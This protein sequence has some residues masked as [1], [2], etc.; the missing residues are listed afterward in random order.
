MKKFVYII[1]IIFLVIFLSAQELQYDVSA[2]N[3]EVPV[4]V[5]KGDRF[6]DH[7]TVDDFEVSEDGVIQKIEAVYLI[8][9]AQ[10]AREDT[11]MNTEEA[12]K[13]YAPQVARNFV[14]V[15][16]VTDYLPRMKEAVDFFFAK[17]ISPEDTLTVVTPLKT[18]RFNKK[19]LT[20]MPREKI[21]SL[22]NERLRMDIT[23]GCR[24]YHSM[25][26]DYLNVMESNFSNQEKLYLLR[27]KIRQF[28]QLRDL[29]GKKILDFADYV[30]KMPGQKFVFL[31]YQREIFPYP[32]IPFESFEYME[33]KSELMTLMP[34]DMAKIKQNYSDS[35]VTIHFLFITRPQREIAAEYDS[36][37]EGLMWEDISSGIF[38][39]FLEMAQST[40]GIADSSA[41]IAFT[42]E[43]AAAASENYYLLYY[44]PMNYAADGK[45]HNIKVKVKGIDCRI[46][47]RAG[48][49]AD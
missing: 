47:H 45:F 29:N 34:Q 25:L 1:T 15:F 2:I 33:L 7:L 22:L 18:Y 3:V 17:V 26:R 20:K 43:K 40:G 12:R 21:S 11:V 16:E 23:N 8:K 32:E 13:K 37:Q 46:T 28:S 27:E 4:R 36:R 6:L 14:L 24:E 19:A 30:K 5:F 35:S 39:T 31:F 44:T 10:I 9:K 41:N 38:A 49:F 42:L 48:Y